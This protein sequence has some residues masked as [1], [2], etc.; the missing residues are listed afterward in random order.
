MS[1]WDEKQRRSPWGMALVVALLVMGG[2]IFLIRFPSV[3]EVT[4][5]T[6][7]MPAGRRHCPV[8]G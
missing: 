5:E 3:P 1:A 2:L 4:S 8:W 6:E 7:G